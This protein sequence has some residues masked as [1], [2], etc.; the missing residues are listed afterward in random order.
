MPITSGK[1]FGEKIIAGMPADINDLPRAQKTTWFNAP[2]G[3]PTVFEMSKAVPFD[4]YSFVVGM[5][6]DDEVIRIYTVPLV[7]PEPKPE[8]WKVRSPTRYILTRAA[9]TFVSEV[10]SLDV[11]ADE[12]IDEWAQVADGMNSAEVEREA[13]IAHLESYGAEPLSPKSLIEEL[14]DEVHLEDDEEEGVP[15]EVEAPSTPPVVVAP[16]PIAST[17]S[18]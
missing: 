12:I 9:P 18:S 6:H 1:E 3:K 2:N 13:V 15:P 4:P 16:T 8:E 10:M 5:F 7:P 11:M 14:R 17:V